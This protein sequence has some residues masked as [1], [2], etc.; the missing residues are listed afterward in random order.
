MS[1]IN[2][3]LLKKF[4]KSALESLTGE[5]VL[6]GGTVLPLLKIE[7]RVTTD[8]DFVGLSKP[9]QEE[10]L[11]LME[12]SE[13]LGLPIESINQAA[14]YF[15]FKIPNF[16]QHL[17]ILER[18]QKTTVYR[19]DMILYVELK[20]PRLSES[21]L[22][23][24]IEYIKFSK[25]NKELPAEGDAKKLLQKIEK[26]IR[27]SHSAERTARLSKLRASLQQLYRHTR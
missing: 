20:L 18:T 23:D 7:H 15:L 8:I 22:M 3:L 17:V 27:S 12:I 9:T 26:Q 10:T 24:C 4:L 5:W 21:D 6:M 16:K 11:K 25:S 14:A 19:P 2:K 13:K 1:L